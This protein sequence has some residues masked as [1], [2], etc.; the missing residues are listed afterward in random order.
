V[1][2]LQEIAIAIFDCGISSEYRAS[3]TED[4]SKAFGKQALEMAVTK[5][6]PLTNEQRE[7]LE[8]IVGGSSASLSVSL[9]S[10]FIVVALLNGYFSSFQEAA[11]NI[12][13]KSQLLLYPA[14]AHLA[15]KDGRASDVRYAGLL[16]LGV[17]TTSHDY[18]SPVPLVKPS[19]RFSMLSIV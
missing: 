7:V 8:A 13:R 14:V 16:P 3:L 19:A 17:P 12:L 10:H 4:I 18:S 11:L 5:A 9:L 6:L 2:A 15:T 1:F